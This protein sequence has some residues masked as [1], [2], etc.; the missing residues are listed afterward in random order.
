MLSAALIIAVSGAFVSNHAKAAK[1]QGSTYNWTEYN[2][3]GVVIG[4]LENATEAQAESTFGCSGSLSV[5]CGVA[6]GGPTI[7]YN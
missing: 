5:K 7:Y 6:D 4:T 1:L 3:Q 2:R